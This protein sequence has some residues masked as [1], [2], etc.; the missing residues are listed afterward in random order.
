VRAILLRLAPLC[1]FF[2][3]TM[4]RTLVLTTMLAYAAAQS[5]DKSGLCDTSPTYVATTLASEC[6][7]LLCSRLR[8]SLPAWLPL[9]VP[10]TPGGP[11]RLRGP[12][13]VP[14]ALLPGAPLPAAAA[15]CCAP[16]ESGSPRTTAPAWHHR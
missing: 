2:Q 8:H 3:V 5:A 10:C 7:K 11:G 15:A 14:R 6:S 16:R 1:T 9:P 4:L 13:A 12:G